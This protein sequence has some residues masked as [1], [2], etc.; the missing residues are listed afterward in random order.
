MIFYIIALVFVFIAVISLFFKRKKWDIIC[1]VALFLSSFF[2]ALQFT[3]NTNRLEKSCAKICGARNLVLGCEQNKIV[4][5]LNNSGGWIT[6]KFK[7]K[8]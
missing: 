8:K 2:I 6:L 5:K 3:I 4:C 7:V 1:M